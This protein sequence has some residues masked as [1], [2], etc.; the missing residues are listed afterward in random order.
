MKKMTCFLTAFML[1]ILY[2]FASHAGE[3]K[4]TD[5]SPFLRAGCVKKDFGML[6]CSNAPRLERFSCKRL[7][8]PQH[9]GGLDAPMVECCTRAK[10]DET[11]V[12]RKGCAMR[13]ICSY[14]VKAKKGFVELK[15]EEEFV[16]YFTPLRTAEGALSLASALKKGNPVYTKPERYEGETSYESKAETIY[17]KGAPAAFNIRLFESKVC[18]C[19]NH[20]IEAVDYKVS[21]SGEIF[22]LSRK[23]IAESK[24][25]LCVD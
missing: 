1:C 25:M 4:E 8:Q 23:K 11:K 9:L 21:P 14:I 5:I 7:W 19:S 18:G 12:I 15:T 16:K 17:E 10:G 6:D 22:E 24:M 2:C 13:L 20:P 3:N